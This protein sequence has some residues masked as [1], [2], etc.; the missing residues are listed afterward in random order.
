MQKLASGAMTSRK[1]Q[2]L[3]SPGNMTALVSKLSYES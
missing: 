3:P 1:S 2:L